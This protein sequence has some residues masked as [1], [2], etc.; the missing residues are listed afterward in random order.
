MKYVS[1]KKKLIV[2]KKKINKFKTVRYNYI[3]WY[4]IA[5]KWEKQMKLKMHMDNFKKYHMNKGDFAI[6]QRT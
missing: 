3:V 4:N 1:W 5:K 6:N 2:K